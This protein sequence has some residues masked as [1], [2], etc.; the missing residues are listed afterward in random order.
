MTQSRKDFKRT[1]PGTALGNILHIL[2]LRAVYPRCRGSRVF[3]IPW[4][5]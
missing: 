2:L 3:P 1:Q 4:L 5:S